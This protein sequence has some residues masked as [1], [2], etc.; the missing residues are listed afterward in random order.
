MKNTKKTPARVGQSIKQTWNIDDIIKSNDWI[1][2]PVLTA[3][4]FIFSYFSTGFYQDDEVAHY[5]TMRDFWND[6]WIIMSNWGKPGWKILLLLPSLLGYKAVLFVNSFIAALT[7]YFVIK[8]AKELKLKNTFLAGIIFGFQ[9]LVLQLAFRSY[10]EIFTGLLLTLTLLCYFRKQYILS[11]I[12]CGWAFTVRQESALLCLILAIY[13]I[14]E[15]KYWQ[16]LF[17]GLLPIILNVIGYL[18]TGDPVWAWTEMK[19][20]SDFNLGIDRSFFHY[21]EVFIFIVGPIT[22]TLFIIGLVK[23]FY[24]IDNRNE[25]YKKELLIYLFFFIVFLFQCYLVIK[26]TNPGSW[27]Y[28]LQ[29]SPVA[30]IIAL[31]GY[32]EVIEMKSKKYVLLSLTGV[33]LM[34]LI[35]FSKEATGLLLTDTKEYYKLLFIFLLTA[36]AFILIYLPKKQDMKTFSVLVIVLTVFYTLYFEKPKQQSAENIAVDEIA[37]WYNNNIDKQIPVL[38]NHSLIFFYGNIFGESK[39]LFNILNMKSLAETPSKSIIIWDSHYSYRPEYKNDTQLNYLL[40]TTKFKLLNQITSSDR[41]FA[42][43]IFEK[44]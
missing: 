35:F 22:F 39:K 29:V 37:R 44:L 8:L 14:T 21:F 30:A 11:A 2:I 33:L 7:A 27:R 13:F 5:I 10:A 34:T 43:Y 18:N 15:R 12:F 31:M 9:P 4:Y 6:P 32:N 19:Q 3:V 41:R 36:G 20:L 1:I 26:G 38:Y 42:A 28:I 25:F 23:P 40:D 24:K 17:I 16:I